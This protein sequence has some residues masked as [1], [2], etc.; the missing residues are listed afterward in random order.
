MPKTPMDYSKCCIYKIEHIEDES[1]VYVGHTTNFDKRKTAHKSNCNNENEPKHNL[2][3]Y[4]MMRTNGGWDMFK[5]IEI[6]KYPC[7]DKREAECRENDVMK[8]LKANMNSNRSYITIEELKDLKEVCD[9][10]YRLIN[11][12]KVKEKKKEYRKNNV[13]MIKAKDKDYSKKCF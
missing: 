4:Q 13:E 3:V 5:M 8:E 1:L 7:K 9:R 6:E 2:K 10:K 12:E 11:T